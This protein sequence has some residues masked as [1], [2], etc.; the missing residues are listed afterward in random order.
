MKDYQGILFFG[1]SL[2][3]AGRGISGPRLRTAAKKAGYDILI[4]DFVADLTADQILSIIKANKTT[5]TK[6]VGFSTSWIENSN[7]AEFSWISKSFFETLKSNFS[8]L[9]IITGGH[10]EINR[11]FILDYS[12]YHFHGFSDNTF[13]EF[14]KMINDQ[15]YKLTLTKNPE[16]FDGFFI[17][18]NNTDPVRHPDDIETVFEKEDNFLSFQPVPIEISRGCIFRCGFCRHPFQGK[19]EYD[20]YQ[21]TPESIARELARNYELFGTTRYTIMDDT[22][23]DSI[24]KID[25]LKRAI[26]IAKLPDF[27]F[28]AY[29]RPEL[30]VTKPEMIAMLSELGLRG[31]FF[32]IESFSQPARQAIGKGINIDRVLD[33]AHKM[34]AYDSRILIHSSLIVGLPHESPDD[35]M[36]SQE[37]LKSKD[38]PFRSWIWQPLGLRNDGISGADA[39]STFDKNFEDYGYSIPLNSNRWSNEHFTMLSANKFAE[40]LNNE[41]S[42]Y[43]KFAGWKVAGAWHI[44]MTDDQIQND[45]YRY[46]YFK[47]ALKKLTTERVTVELNKLLTNND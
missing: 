30:L 1:Q 2:E 6:F 20:S 18:S 14:I 21:R 24:E 5:S 29:I 27:E 35:I 16:L 9:K 38:S 39:Q 13:V 17:D 44:N 33:A 10:D 8:D 7:L 12:D 36:R 11:E 32:G 43:Q 46:K 22:F 42:V 15:S 31:A 23:N 25:R 40:K 45:I 3:L 28:V 26:E 4:I 19:K 34:V 41:A 47:D 37:F